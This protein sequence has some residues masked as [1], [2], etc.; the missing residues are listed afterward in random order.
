MRSAS[1]RFFILVLS[2]ATF[3]ACSTRVPV[4][5]LQAF[6]GYRYRDAIQIFRQKAATEEGKDVVLYQLALLSAAM[7]AGDYWDA[8][9]SALAAMR[10]MGSDAGKGRGQASLVSSEALKVFKGEPFE[11]SMAAIYLGIIY[12]NRGDLDNA[13]AAFGKATMAIQ[14]KEKNQNDFALAY[15]LQAKTFLRLGDEDSARVALERARKSAPGNPYLQIEKLKASNALFIVELGWGP[16]K[17]RTGPGASLVEWK[18]RGYP[19]RSVRVD[20]D[21]VEM[22]AAEEAGDL[23][24]QAKTKGWTGKDTLQVTKGATREAAAVTTV[25]AADMASKGNET[26]GWVALGAGLFTLLNQSEADIRQW[27]LLPDRLHILPARLTAGRHTIRLRFSGVGG[28]PLP[29]YDQTWYEVPLA[30]GEDRIFLF[31]SGMQKGISVG[32]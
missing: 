14:Q 19:E 13:R 6:G 8:E 7:T 11:K 26:A 22:G 4:E 17:T 29:S 20:V 21:G 31:R 1:V 25:I 12:Y 2:A 18:R 27:E 9:K 16:A 23:T 5:G 30:G 15:L 10:V 24:Y 32:D 3:V 28:P